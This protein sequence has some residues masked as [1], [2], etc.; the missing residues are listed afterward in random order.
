MKSLPRRGFTL[1]EMLATMTVGSIILLVAATMLGHAGDGYDRGSG[2]VAAER[3]G[4]A[5][6]TQMADDLSKAV[7]QPDTRI[8]NQGDSWKRA[9]LGFFSLQASDAQSE[10]GRLADL[11]TVHYYIK[12]IQVGRATVRCLMRGFHESSETLD[13]LR[14]GSIDS[15]FK[16]ENKDEPVAFGVLAF[17]ATPL[18]RGTSGKWEDWVKSTETPPS[19]LRL[20]LIVARRELLGKLQ[21][22]SDW[23]SSPLRGNPA[24]PERSRYLEIYEVIQRFGNPG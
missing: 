12:D 24:E 13:G 9:D 6:L 22:S 18:V 11:C 16:P 17:E 5:V 21:T 2:G 10:D 23:D 20:K 15:L 4:R 14:G 1:V 8:E 19:A 7:W 3:E